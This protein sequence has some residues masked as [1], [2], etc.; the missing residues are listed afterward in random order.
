MLT[1]KVESLGLIYVVFKEKEKGEVIGSLDQC[2]HLNSFQLYHNILH[3]SVGINSKAAE[4]NFLK[5][6]RFQD[7]ID[8]CT[9]NLPSL[10]R[11]KKVQLDIYRTQGVISS[12]W[13]N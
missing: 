9:S 1:P 5:C 12:D 3:T 2:S 6:E 7:Q 4:L 13:M 10:N 8:C 11:N